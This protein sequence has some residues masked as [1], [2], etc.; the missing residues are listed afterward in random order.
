MMESIEGNQ[1][2]KAQDIVKNLKAVQNKEQQRILKARYH[3][4]VRY[5]LVSWISIDIVLINHL[6]RH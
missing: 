3:S 4:K 1:T 2:T 5:E 6:K